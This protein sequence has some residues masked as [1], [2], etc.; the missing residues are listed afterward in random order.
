MTTELAG[1]GVQLHFVRGDTV[2]FTVI[3]E[4][5]DGNGVNQPIDLTDASLWCTMKE[6]ADQDDDDAFIA[7]TSPYN[8]TRGINILDQTTYPGQ[9]QITAAAGESSA[10]IKGR[11]YVVDV[12]VKEADGTVTTPVHGTIRFLDEVT[13]ATS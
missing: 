8:G 12:Q 13:R 9:A 1:A 11:S 2:R 5:P 3:C 7:L 6:S 4:R 10:A